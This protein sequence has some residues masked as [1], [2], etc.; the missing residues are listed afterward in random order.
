MEINSAWLLQIAGYSQQK[1]DWGNQHK[2]SEMYRAKAFDTSG[3]N[4]HSL[5]LVEFPKTWFIRDV[6]RGS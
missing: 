6:G 1:G 4:F 3:F 2:D 5:E